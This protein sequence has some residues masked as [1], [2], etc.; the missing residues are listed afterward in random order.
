MHIYFLVIQYYYSLFVL[1]IDMKYTSLAG[2]ELF[3]T[4][5]YLSTHNKF[6]TL[7]LSVNPME[8]R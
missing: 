5:I 8:R 3:L 1:I 7:C 6:I 2:F 4:R